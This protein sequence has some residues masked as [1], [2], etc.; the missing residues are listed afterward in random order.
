MITK[1]LRRA[2]LFSGIFLL[3]TSVVGLSVLAA[4]PKAAPPGGHLNVTEVLVD[5]PD[6]PT[7][8]TITGEDFD[9]GPGPLVVTLGGFGSLSILS[10]TGT[11]IVATLP[12]NISDGDF[13]LTVS[14]GNG[15]SQN[16]EYDLTIGAVGAT[17]PTGPQGEQG[18]VGPQGEQG[19]VGPQGEQGPQGKIG[20]QGVQGKIGLTGDTGP[21]GVQGKIGP[22]GD[23]GPQGKVGPL[24]PQGAIDLGRIQTFR[25]IN[26]SFISC[27]PGWEAVGGG[28]ICPHTHIASTD[29]HII[30]TRP[31][32]VVGNAAGW[33]VSCAGSGL[34][35]SVHPQPQQVYV[36]CVS[37]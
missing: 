33:M 28:G 34:N 14:T 5:D 31:S 2:A 4:H 6:N 29:S 21:Q 20:V 1:L 8:I 36:L 16:Y 25:A 35:H 27:P 26:T 24:G 17:G 22:Q 10:A 19:E 3:S 9:F 37:P 12:A 32:P 7:S 23:Q 30:M 13:L 15:Q 11:E 18:K